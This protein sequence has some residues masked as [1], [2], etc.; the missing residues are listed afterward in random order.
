MKS[1][2]H[3]RLLS[4][5]V[6]LLFATALGAQVTYQGGRSGGAIHISA[7]N[8]VMFSAGAN[9]VPD[10]L[11]IGVASGGGNT[12]MRDGAGHQTSSL[13]LSQGDVLIFATQAPYYLDFHG[14]AM[15]IF[16]GG[17]ILNGPTAPIC[18]TGAEGPVLLTVNKTMNFMAESGLSGNPQLAVTSYLSTAA[19]QNGSLAYFRVGAYQNAGTFAFPACSGSDC[20]S[21]TSVLLALKNLSGGAFTAFELDSTGPSDFDWNTSLP[22]PLSCEASGAPTSGNAPLKVTFSASASG[23]SP[24][25]TWE[26]KFGDGATSSNHNPSH[27]Y[28]KGG[29]FTWKMTATDQANNSCFR[30]GTIKV[31]GALAATATANPRQGMPPFTSTFSTTVAGGNPPYTYAWDFADG[32]TANVPNPTHTFVSSGVFDC[33]VTVKDKEGKSAAATA[34]VYSGVPIPP[35]VT[36]VTSLA[37][38]FRLKVAGQDFMNGCTAFIN[39]SQVPQVVFKTPTSLVFKGGS[40]LK[41]LVPKGASVCVRVINPDGTSSECYT[42]VR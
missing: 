37:N 8:L 38:P 10:G 25:F 23:G 22:S 30:T 15:Q 13:S 28:D 18:K 3:L 12:T 17:T 24:G 9:P 34:N 26:W 19:E 16:Y 14:S 2:F 21:P 20:C 39:D 36:G 29:T 5:A 40:S 11:W 4:L 33:Q 7:G 42:Y 31:T 1:P 6:T 35:T 41:A 27:T 32:G